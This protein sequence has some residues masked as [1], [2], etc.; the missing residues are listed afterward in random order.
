MRFDIFLA[1]EKDISRNKAA[2]LINEKS[3]L[4][5]GSFYKASFDVSTLLPPFKIELLKELYVSRAA[6]KLKGF[7]PQCGIDLKAAKG[8]KA[9]DIGSSHGGFVQVLLEYSF[10][11]VAVDVG[12]DQLHAS[13]KP[14]VILHENT[15]IREFKSEDEFFVIT[16]DVSFISLTSL[17]P[18]INSFKTSFLILLFKPEFEVG[19]H[20][21]RNKRGVL[22]N[23]ADVKKARDLF[24]KESLKLGWRLI[25]CEPS[26]VLGKEG[27][28]EYFYSFA[29]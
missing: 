22:K 9:L 11:V 27:N 15:D 16:A 10:E 19:R 21:K 20:A 4:L 1:K 24:L 17:L 28:L 3:V 12:K 2:E 7:L 18:F 8:K 23:K 14:R 13:L 29:K 26:L 5:N 6:Y 25:A